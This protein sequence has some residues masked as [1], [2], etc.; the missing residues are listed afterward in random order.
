M[1]L[2]F[3]ELEIG[4]PANPSVAEKVEFLMLSGAIYS[5]VPTSTLEKLEIWPI[6]AQEFI[7]ANGAKIVCAKKAVAVFKQGERIGRADVIFGED[8]NSVLLGAFTLE[9]PGL[10]LDLLYREL[11]PLSMVFARSGAERFIRPRLGS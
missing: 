4:N 7:L 3:L 6:T 11:K 9:A 2:T 10:V 8:G 5:V 1:S